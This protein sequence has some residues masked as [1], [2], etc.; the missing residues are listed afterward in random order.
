VLVRL[1]RSFQ[2]QPLT[3]R[4]PQT[5]CVLLKPGIGGPHAWALRL[6]ERLGTERKVLIGCGGQPGGIISDPDFCFADGR[7]LVDRLVEMAPAVVIPN[8]LWDA[9]PI[10]TEVKE[11]GEQITVIGYCR[12]DDDET[13]YRPLLRH[14]RECDWIVAVSTACRDGLLR[15]LPDRSDRIRLVRTF[16][17]RPGQLHRDWQGSPLRLLYAGRLEQLH[18]R[19]FDLAEVASHL[20]TRGVPYELRIAGV[21]ADEAEL[22]SRL[23]Q[24]PDQGRAIFLGMLSASQLQT[25]YEETDAVL[26]LS[27]TEGLSNALLEGMAH[28]CVPVT[29]RTSAELED[30][31]VGDLG[32]LLCEVGD[33]PGIVST[34]SELRRAGRLEKLGRL[35]HAVTTEF[36][37]DAYA[38]RFRSLLQEV[39]AGR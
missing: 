19:V 31:L 6:R 20:I 9:Y 21:G 8:W 14:H 18:K 27:D 7:A 11:R 29:T 30:L 16:V 10:C 35:S 12:S 1:R 22:R 3:D 15:R 32:D 24:L 2:V 4:E 26:L 25:L 33:I 38:P 37:W 5:L 13:Y 23:N 36:G 17:D 39:E 28:G 34:I